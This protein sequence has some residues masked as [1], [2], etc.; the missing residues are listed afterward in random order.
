VVSSSWASS[1]SRSTPAPWQFISKVDRRSP[2]RGSRL[3][4]RLRE[5]MHGL[6]RAYVALTDDV[7]RG[8]RSSPAAEWLLDNFHTLA[9]SARDIRHD[10]PPAY[11]RRLPT[12]RAVEFAG[13]PRVYALALE[14]I[15]NS[16]RRLDAQRL[17]RFIAAFQTVTPLTIGELWAWPSVLKLALL[18]HLRVRADVLAAGR[19]HRMEADRLAGGTEAENPTDRKFKGPFA[20]GGEVGRGRG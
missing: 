9:A 19:A 20:A 12:A 14:L 15:G 18:D 13:L 7:R 10:L 1:P 4:D 2:R 6:R 5:H 8:E 11:S 17:H 3:L 16:A